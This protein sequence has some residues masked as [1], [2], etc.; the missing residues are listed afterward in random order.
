MRLFASFKAIEIYVICV[1]ALCLLAIDRLCELQEI[2]LDNAESLSLGQF[3]ILRSVDLF[4]KDHRKHVVAGSN[5]TTADPMTT[6]T[7]IAV[8]TTTTSEASTSKTAKPTTTVVPTTT[9]TVAPTKKVTTSTAAPVTTTTTTAAT[10]KKVTTTKAPETPTKAPATP[11]PTAKPVT[12]SLGPGTPLAKD[13]G[14]TKAAEKPAESGG[15]WDKITGIFDKRRKRQSEQ[16]LVRQVELEEPK[17]PEQVPSEYVYDGTKQEQMEGMAHVAEPKHVH[18]PIPQEDNHE[19]DHDHDRAHEHHHD[20]QH[21]DDHK[22]ETQ[23]P[24]HVHVAAPETD[25]P[26]TSAASS[27]K[28]FSRPPVREIPVIDPQYTNKTAIGVYRC[29]LTDEFFLDAFFLRANVPIY[30]RLA[31]SRYWAIVLLGIHLLS[32]GYHLFL[33]VRHRVPTSQRANAMFSTF[34]LVIWSF[35][36]GGVVCLGYKWKDIFVNE[37]T[38]PEFPFLLY[39]FSMIYALMVGIQILQLI[40]PSMFWW[41]FDVLPRSPRLGYMPAAQSENAYINGIIRKLETTDAMECHI[42]TTKPII[43]SHE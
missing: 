11:T 42:D 30:Q 6:T 43:R 20:H 24:S 5:T 18:I 21:H 29:E 26:V 15:V 1:G 27:A 41:S 14:T 32:V 35:I 16:V 34:G 10:T 25:K 17:V 33:N 3:S 4:V 23:K 19:H 9:S 13:D 38:S 39:T 40:F 2:S 22:H 36:M 7:P 12:P 37:P 28:P 8:T 31:A